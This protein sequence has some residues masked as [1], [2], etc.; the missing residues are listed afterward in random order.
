MSRQSRCPLCF[1]VT[2]DEGRCDGAATCHNLGHTVHYPIQMSNAEAMEQMRT[3]R[4]TDEEAEDDRQHRKALIVVWL[5][6]G[7]IIALICWQYI[8]AFFNH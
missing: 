4:I 6:I 8:P 7:A 3:K 5:T 2:D 1:Y